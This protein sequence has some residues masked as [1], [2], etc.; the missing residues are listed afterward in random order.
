MLTSR[1]TLITTAVVVAALFVIATP[2][3]D[4]HHGLGKHNKAVA[5]LGQVI[6]I[7]FVI[8]AV[9]LIALSLIAVARLALARRATR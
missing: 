1:K 4:A 6:F 2:L 3:G 9:V 7:G 5:D 8:S